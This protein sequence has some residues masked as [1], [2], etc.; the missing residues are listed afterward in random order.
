MN[1]YIEYLRDNPKGYWFKRKLFGW[2]W[3]PVKWQG[4]LVVLAYI[5][6]LVLIAFRIDSNSHSVS[7]TLVTFFLPFIITT[8]I[9]ILICYK[10][11]EKPKWMWGLPEK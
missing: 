2:G 11:G 7:D 10:T 4:W 5:V 9:L 6:S 8:G 1:K 3:T